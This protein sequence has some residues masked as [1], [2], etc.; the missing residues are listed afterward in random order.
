MRSDPSSLRRLLVTSLAAAAV[1]LSAGLGQTLEA[2][3]APRDSA[4]AKKLG[5][6]MKDSRVQRATSAAVVVDGA[7][8]SVLYSR[9]AGRATTPASNTKI[10]TAVAAMDTLGPNYRFK[11]DVIR[12]GKV[13]NGTLRGNLYLKG[14]GDPTTMTSDFRALAE[15]VRASGI[16]R[17]TRKVV[18][19]ASFF[20]SA[21]YN[22]HWSTSY[23][24]D[25]YAAQI[26]ALTAAP[27]RDYDSGT[28][29]VNYKPARVG[30]RASLKLTPASAAKYV[31]IKNSTRT[32]AKRSS[33]SLSV[34]RTPGTNTV[35]VSGRVPAGRGG[36]KK[37]VT[38][39]KPELYAAAL[40]RAE[41]IKAGV[42]VVGGTKIMRTPAGSRTLVARDRSMTL[43]KL[44]VPF[45]KLSN[46]MHAEAL[47]KTMATR[48]GRPGSW[49][50]GLT[51]TRAYMRSLGAP[52]RGIVLR[53][54]SGLTRSNKIT[55]RAMGVVLDKVQQ[56]KW[57][58][59]F[60]ASL[61]VAGHSDRMTGGTLTKRMKRTK[62]AG[63]A[64]AK[65]GTLTRVTALSGYVRG[66]DGR[67]YIFSMMSQYTGRTPRP[68]EDKLVV[69]L[70]NHRRR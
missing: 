69:V 16:R 57:F 64:H 47:T 43:S 32:G 36:G 7:T 5:A 28:V 11:T 39:N 37:W 3:A 1:L 51:Y 20:D 27:N 54:G 49:A 21:R 62:A 26:S 48:T 55:P 46:N 66:S 6:V 53:D 38:V 22:P 70:A 13:S 65:T 67:R 12:R 41:L 35:T 42:T 52:M 34:R 40:F 2:A 68:V 8:G 63:N 15:K 19:D 44:L 9:Y 24:S 23:A 45:M 30:K 18:A 56:E 29:I 58:P 17:V 59:A 25:Y 60:Y 61:P 31:K 33:N 50:D 10:L 4:L 14:Y